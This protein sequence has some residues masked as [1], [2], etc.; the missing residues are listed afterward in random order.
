VSVD[1]KKA[2]IC[3]SAHNIARH[4][5]HMI[6]ALCEGSITAEYAFITPHGNLNFKLPKGD[7]VS[8]YWYAGRLANYQSFEPAGT[9]K[10][11][12]QPQQGQQS[13]TSGYVL[14]ASCY[15][16][17]ELLQGSCEMVEQLAEQEALDDPD[18]AKGKAK[19]KWS[20][21]RVSGCPHGHQCLVNTPMMT[22][23]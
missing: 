11:P 6:T 9:S 17:R 19:P 13:A 5:K 10:A 20:S 8:G 18:Q 16:P 7:K 12:A 21:G 23:S 14:R 1:W 22:T 2:A 4:Q 15:L 3:S